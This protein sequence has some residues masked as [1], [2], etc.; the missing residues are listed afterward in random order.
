MVRGVPPVGPGEGI[1]PR[2]PAAPG[3]GEI[4]QERLKISAHAQ[5]RLS[6][7][8]GPEETRRLESAMAEAER[9]GAKQSLV[10][11]GDLALIVSVANRTVI[12]ALGPERQQPNTVVTGIDSAVIIR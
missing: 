11:L 9:K 2:T 4:L 1:R 8:L 5:S 10:L 6:G 3:F 7:G 12:T